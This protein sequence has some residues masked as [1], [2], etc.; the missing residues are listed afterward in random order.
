MKLKQFKNPAKKISA[1]GQ[2]NAALTL[3]KAQ[4]I[5]Y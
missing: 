1:A 3:T 5:L 4:D 2:Y